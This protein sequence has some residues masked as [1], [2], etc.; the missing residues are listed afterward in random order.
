[1]KADSAIER[2][3]AKQGRARITLAAPGKRQNCG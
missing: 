2:S 3:Q 1:M